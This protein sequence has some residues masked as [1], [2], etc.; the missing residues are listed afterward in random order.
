MLANLAPSSPSRE[1][2][3]KTNQ[4]K[5]AYVIGMIIGLLLLLP[6]LYIAHAHRLNGF[7][8]RIFYDI[9]NLPNGYRVPALWITEGLGSAIPIA[10]CV[11]LP[12]L[13]KRFRLAWR[14]FFTAGGAVAVM[15]VA[16]V[17]TKEPRPVILL[18]HHLQL[19][20]IETGP[21][22]PSGHETAATAL[23]LTLWLV[24]PTKWRWL[25][26]VWILLVA[27]SRLYLGVHAPVDIVGGFAIGLMAVCFVRLLPRVIAKP[28]R[29]DA[30][31]SLL[32]PGF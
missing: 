9:N 32:E 15:E 29:L 22:F 10:I 28:L 13:F 18:A 23:A 6:A 19:R 4:P 24:L 2:T 8:A 3:S 17:L 5:T 30:D 25:S 14:F 12:A 11:L 1:Q 26:L 20:A 31:H 21:A 7:Q 27:V 16:K